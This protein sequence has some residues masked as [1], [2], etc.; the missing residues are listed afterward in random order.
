MTAKTQNN[1]TVRVRKLKNLMLFI[2]VF[3]I[4]A[5][6]TVIS[7][8]TIQKTDEAL[9]SKVTTMVS[10]LNVQMQKNLDSY[11]QRM[12]TIGTLIFATE[13]VYEY[14]PVGSPVGEYEA[15]KTETL[16]EDQLYNICIMENFV[17]FSIVYSDNHHVGKMS[18]GTVK[19]FG[20]NLYTDLTAM[21]NRQKTAD[22]WSTGYGGNYKRIYYVKRVNENAVLVISFY[23]D[24]LEDVFEHPGGIEDITVS[25]VE[26]SNVVIYSS[27]DSNEGEAL[28]DDIAETINN[29]S[30]VTIMDDNFLVTVQEC[31]DKWHVVCSAPTKVILK[32]KNDV[33]YYVVLTAVVASILATIISIVIMSKILSPVNEIVDTLADEAHTDL[34]TG[35]LN[36]RTFEK[37]VEE[38]LSKDLDNRKKAIIL[39]DLDNFKGVN[40]TLGHAYGDKVLANV[41]DIMKRVFHVDDY[42]GRLGGDEFCVYL[43][44][45]DIQQG[46]YLAHIEEKCSELSQ[47]FRHNYTGENNN[48]KISASIGAAVF[49]IHGRNFSD[50]YKC[51]DKALYN[52]KHKGKDTFTIY[53]EVQE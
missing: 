37:R 42:L 20:G 19:L 50:L 39:I 2:N 6:T 46:N 29:R 10:A 48:Y 24:E 31:G 51:A 3:I 26:E 36:K 32:E 1:S 11:L 14:D 15:I 7:V 18:N 21:I 44:I 23:T 27:D 49:P 52:S 30:A 35:I 12:E 40:D 47:E 22:G 25:L 43:N 34:L 4:V 53:E 41:G 16:I 5:L 45:S 9:K 38:A 8:L 28:S 17:D 33:T 13:E